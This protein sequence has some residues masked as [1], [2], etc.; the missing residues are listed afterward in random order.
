MA[1]GLPG[2]LAHRAHLGALFVVR[3]ASCV[4]QEASQSEDEI[5]FMRPASRD[6]MVM[7]A[8][9]ASPVTT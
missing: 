6:S 8:V 3:E 9:A 1:A 4:S 7:R 2:L 5:H